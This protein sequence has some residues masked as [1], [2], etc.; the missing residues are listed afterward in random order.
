MVVTCASLGQGKLASLPVNVRAFRK[1]FRTHGDRRTTVGF[2]NESTTLQK[3]KIP[4][5]L[6][7]LGATNVLLL[8]APL[9]AMAETCET[10]QSLFSMNMPLLLLVALIGATVG[11]LL[12]RQR[13]GELQRL[14]EQ[15]RQINTALKRQ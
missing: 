7:E 3:I 11:G 12:A 10:E 15:L 5:T 9:E 2:A 6:K 1:T 14:N 8:A 13:K 4:R